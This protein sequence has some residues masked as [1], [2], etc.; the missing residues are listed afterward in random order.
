[1][2]EMKSSSSGLLGVLASN[3]FGFCLALLAEISQTF[4]Q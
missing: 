4:G 3:K 2:E 1:M